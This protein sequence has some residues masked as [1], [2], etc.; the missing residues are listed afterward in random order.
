M[1]NYTQISSEIRTAQGLR[2]IDTMVGRTPLRDW[3]V[4]PVFLV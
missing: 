4:Y 1:D 2:H 3:R